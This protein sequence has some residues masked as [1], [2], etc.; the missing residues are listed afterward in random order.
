MVMQDIKKVSDENRT[1]TANSRFAK[2]GGV[3]CFSDSFVFRN[4]PLRQE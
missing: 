4:P 2:A 3:T 1:T